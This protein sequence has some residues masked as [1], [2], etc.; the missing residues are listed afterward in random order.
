MKF[1]KF[2][3]FALVFLWLSGCASRERFVPPASEALEVAKPGVVVVIPDQREKTYVAVGL[4]RALKEWKVPVRSIVSSGFGSFIAALYL[5]SKTFDEFEWKLSKVS[6]ELFDSKGF[7]IKKILRDEK[8]ARLKTLLALVKDQP[9]QSLHPSLRV[10][11]VLQNSEGRV[12]ITRGSLHNVLRATLADDRTFPLS[13]WRGIVANRSLDASLLGE[14]RWNERF[15]YPVI[16]VLADGYTMEQ[17]SEVSLMIEAPDT[18]AT[19][20]AVSFSGYEASLEEKEKI[21]YLSGM[22]PGKEIQP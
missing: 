11:T 21:L 7:S 2:L 19:R 9:L 6:N 8:T 15:Q 13:Q 22:T 14:M 3:L 20:S 12:E 10:W 16:G 4:L 1:D 5:T 17:D 18:E